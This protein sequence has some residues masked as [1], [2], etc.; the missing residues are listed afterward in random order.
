MTGQFHSF[1]DYEM[2]PMYTLTL[3]V[4]GAMKGVVVPMPAAITI[5][6]PATGIAANG[7]GNAPDSWMTNAPTPMVPSPN[8]ASGAR[9]VRGRC[10]I[11]P[12]P[13]AS[14]AP[15]PSSHTRVNVEKYAH[16]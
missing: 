5:A 8:Q 15:T 13:M 11:Q 16:D 12:A 3:F 6:A 2:S 1:S 10:E 7:A 4:S 9:V 14:N